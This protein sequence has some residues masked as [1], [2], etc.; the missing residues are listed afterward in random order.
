VAE[1][2]GAR[3]LAQDYGD[4][5]KALKMAEKSAHIDATLRLAG[6]SEVFTQD[7][8]DRPIQDD[9]ASPPQTSTQS[10][11]SHSRTSGPS[12]TPPRPP[13]PPHPTDNGFSTPPRPVAPAPATS[14]SKS[15]A[16][17]PASAPTSANDIEIINA[18]DV[19]LIEQRIANIGIAEKRVLAWLNKVTKGAVTRFDQLNVVQCTS[20]LKRLD[21]WAE[22][23]SAQSQAAA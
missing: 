9:D 23:V 5:N 20:L 21:V 8:E 16:R 15:T 6:L 11:D 18:D 19:S 17:K 14:S 3:S 12:Q 10:R 13:R 2:V 22:E 1:G 4:V 7:I